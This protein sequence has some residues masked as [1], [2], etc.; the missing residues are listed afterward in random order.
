MRKRF[1]TGEAS[2]VGASEMANPSS[3]NN[4]SDGNSRASEMANLT[5]ATNL[6]TEVSENHPHFSGYRAFLKLHSK[7]VKT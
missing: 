5:A 1:R 6:G 4:L 2:T 7:V 3:T